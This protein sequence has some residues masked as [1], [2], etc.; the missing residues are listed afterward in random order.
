MEPDHLV[1][2]KLEIKF[3]TLK[4]IKVGNWLKIKRSELNKKCPRTMCSLFLGWAGTRGE[5]EG[6]V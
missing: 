6:N 4:S 3:H 5:L 2:S 1:F